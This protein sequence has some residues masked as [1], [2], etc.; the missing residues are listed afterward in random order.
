MGNSKCSGDLVV[1]YVVEKITKKIHLLRLDDDET[2]YFEGVWYIPEGVTYNSYLITTSEGVV[3]VD[4]WKIG[5][6]DLFLEVVRSIADPRDISYIVVNHA[7][8]D[9]SGTVKSLHMQAEKATIVGHRVAIQLLQS[10]YGIN[11]RLK[12][13]EDGETLKISREEQLVFYHTPWLHWPDT[14]I[15]YHAGEKALFSCDVFGSYGIPSKVFYEDLTSEEKRLIT[16]YSK[17]Y[18]V[19]I[20]A[21]YADWVIKALDKLSSLNIDVNIV[22][23]GH[24]PLYKSLAHVV[25]LYREL[26]SKKPVKGKVVLVYTT[27]YGFVREA[28]DIIKEELSRRGVEVVVWEFSDRYHPP[29]SEVLVD[30]YEAEVV[31]IGSATYD[32]DLFPLGKLIAEVMKMKTHS[33]GKKVAIVAAAGWGPVAGSKLRALLVERGFNVVDIVEFKGRA[34]NVESKLRELVSKLV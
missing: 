33:L 19:N 15:T 6:E 9:H 11:E 12:H 28:F 30:L 10:F 4:G 27:M 26:G 25:P 29:I 8:P 32:A 5:Y 3:V 14:M 13:V 16:H 7:E 22:A 24:G 20:I 31:V 18:F 1:K 17:K 21:K 2:K 23:P 34:K